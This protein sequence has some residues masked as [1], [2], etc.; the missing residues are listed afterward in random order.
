MV[1]SPDGDP[2]AWVFENRVDAG[3]KTKRSAFEFVATF[4]VIAGLL[5]LGA[6]II[7]PLVLAVLLAFALTPLVSW[8]NRRAHLPDALAVIVAVAFAILL[9]GSLVGLAGFQIMRLAQELPG[10][11]ETVAA[12]LQ[13]LQQQLGGGAFLERINATIS[14]FSAQLTAEGAA[15]TEGRPVPVAITNDNGPFG[16]LTSVLGSIVGPVATVA[17]VAI[18]LIFLLLGRADLLDRF[19]RLVGSG[20]YSKAN[21]AIADASKRVGR[22]LLVQL[23][24]NC[25]YGVIFGLG[26]W[27]IGVPSAVLWGLLI[28]VFRY[29][30]FIGALIIAIVPFLLAFAVDPGWNMLIMSVSLFLVLD[31]TTANIIEPRLYGSSTGV[32]PLAILLSAMFWATLWGPIGL[33]LATPMTVCLVVIGRHLPQFGFLDTMLGSDPVL[34]PPE[35]LYQRMLK[36]DT[37]SAMETMEEHAGEHGTD[38]Y[39]RDVLFP[40]IKLASH[41]LTD[42]PEALQ[43][44]RQ[45]VESF[46]LLLA[47]AGLGEHQQQQSVIIVGAK[48]ELDETAAKL[49]GLM[50]DRQDVASTVL[51]PLAVRPEAIGQLDVTGV[52]LVVLVFM[53]SNIGP[54]ARYISRRLRRI[55]PGIRLV[56]CA[57][58]SAESEETADRLHVDAIY[59]SEVDAVARIAE[60]VAMEDHPDSLPSGGLLSLRSRGDELLAQSLQ[61]IANRFNVPV[62]SVNLLDDERHKEDED[63]YRLTKLVCETGKP[64]I[65]PSDPPNPA[66]AANA[67]LQTGG[68]HLYAGV[69][70]NLPSGECVGALVLLDYKVHPLTGEEVAALV[71]AGEELVRRFVPAVEAA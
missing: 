68:I 65:I 55:N 4:A 51:P 42:R 36:G 11:Q 57:L 71:E 19:I 43:Q 17:I 58:G 41:E 64:V 40:A 39:L 24:V 52:R 44:R 50:L 37:V 26:L 47:E 3:P 10:Y 1:Q 9:L 29:I 22:Y 70:L 61:Q 33:I 63:A 53:G 8:L 45:L 5:Y 35:Q 54:Q 67:Y 23:A 14:D 7:V 27:L 18:F 28:V 21:I 48:T 69:P 56:V 32:S 62:A 13:G 60:N 6:G 25:V 2:E 30:P 20:D 46:D 34:T 38:A 12:K 31:L 66:L 59:R 49:L 15:G 16:L